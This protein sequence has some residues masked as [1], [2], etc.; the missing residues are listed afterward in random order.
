MQ[1]SSLNRSREGMFTI[2][3]AWHTNDRNASW[4]PT[5]QIERRDTKAAVWVRSFVQDQEPAA[6]FTQTEIAENERSAEE[7]SL[8]AVCIVVALKEADD[9]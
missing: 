4:I 1:P 3:I 2:L 8:K 7:Q 9:G 5:F 6:S